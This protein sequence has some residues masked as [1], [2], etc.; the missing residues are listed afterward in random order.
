MIPARNEFQELRI[1]GQESSLGFRLTEQQTIILYFDKWNWEMKHDSCLALLVCDHLGIL[2]N[3][4]FKISLSCDQFLLDTII[5][6][7]L[8]WAK[9][10]QGK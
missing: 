8:F 1:Y 5:I 6:I 2:E 10:D 4:T 7:V 9:I 3:M